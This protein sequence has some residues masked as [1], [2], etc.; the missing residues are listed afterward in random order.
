[1]HSESTASQTPFS[2]A[3]GTTCADMWIEAEFITTTPARHL[4]W[5]ETESR[6]SCSIFCKF[7]ERG[8]IDIKLQRGNSTKKIG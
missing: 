4:C 7:A 6:V 8:I 2:R 3:A 1:M 5:E